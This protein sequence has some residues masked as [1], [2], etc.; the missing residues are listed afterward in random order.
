MVTKGHAKV[1]DAKFSW[2]QLKGAFKVEH[3]SEI[4]VPLL[5]CDS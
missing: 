4:L 2:H 5:A 3:L 1:R